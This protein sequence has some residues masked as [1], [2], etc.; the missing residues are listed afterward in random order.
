MKDRL[1]VK[2]DERL[3]DLAK[4]SDG[5][6]D[7]KRFPREAVRERAS[8]QIFHDVMRRIRIPADLKKMHHPALAEHLDELADFTLQQ[9]QVEPLEAGK[10]LDRD[11]AARVL[12][13]RKPHFAIGARAKPLFDLV[14][15]DLGLRK[16]FAAVPRART[17]PLI[18]SN[19]QLVFGWALFIVTH[20]GT[21]I[22]QHSGTAIQFGIQHSA[23]RNSLD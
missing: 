22:L 14:A 2:I 18:L 17:L 3:R 21:V 9:W 5:I 13:H 19:G 20:G 23:F 6:F 7:R 16:L 11:F 15:H 12:L 8:R 10:E 1:A 4:N